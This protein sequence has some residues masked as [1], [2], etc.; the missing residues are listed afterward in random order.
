MGIGVCG[1]IGQSVM[2]LVK[3]EYKIEQEFVIIHLLNMGE[4]YVLE[5]LM[6]HKRAI[7]ILVQVRDLNVNLFLIFCFTYVTW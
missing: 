6:K 4:I 3:E 5:L 7:L 2:Q 1:Q